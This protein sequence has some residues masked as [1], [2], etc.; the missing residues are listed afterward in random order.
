MNGLLAPIDL[1]SHP[2]KNGLNQEY[3]TKQPPAVSWWVL[4][5]GL[6]VQLKP[7][8]YAAGTDVLYMAPPCIQA[9]G[10]L[11]FNR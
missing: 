4:F 9:L 6:K 8:G 7:A 3:K 2:D 1:I 11:I 10:K 5:S